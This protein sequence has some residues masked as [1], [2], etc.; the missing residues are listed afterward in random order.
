MGA[1]LSGAFVAYAPRP[2]VLVYLVYL[3]L[4]VPALAGARLPVRL[5]PL[6]LLP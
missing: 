2:T 1:F 4:L 6:G 5:R 3:G